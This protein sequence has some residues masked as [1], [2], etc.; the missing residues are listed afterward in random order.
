METGVKIALPGY[1]ARTAPDYNLSFSS[2]WPMEQITQT[3][4]HTVTSADISNTDP[5]FSSPTATITLTHNMGYYAFADVWI[6][7]NDSNF[8]GVVAERLNSRQLYSI[9]FGKNTIKLVTATSILVI[10]DQYTVYDMAV[11]DI[12]SV[13]VYS[14]DFTQAFSYAAI[15]PPVG[16]APY[17]PHIGI[18]IV[19]P[20]RNIDSTDLRDFII[21]SKGSAPQILTVQTLENANVYYTVSGSSTKETVTYQIPN[22]IPAR[23]DFLYSTSA[24]EWSTG[25]GSPATQI[26]ESSTGLPYFSSVFGQYD[27]QAVGDV[28]YQMSSSGLFTSFGLYKTVEFSVIVRRDPLLYSAPTVVAL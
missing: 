6:Y 3:I 8:G 1:D 28:S 21:H 26:T 10:G 4:S 25:T 23:I 5:A 2:N 12:I 9:Y 15:L 18:K 27:T 19:R 22:R 14:F 13:K 20:G 17:D 24:T 7:K 16:K 11:G